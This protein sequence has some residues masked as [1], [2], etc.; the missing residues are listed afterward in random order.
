MSRQV[1]TKLDD[2]MLHLLEYICIK[3]EVHKTKQLCGN[4]LSYDQ[5]ISV[6]SFPIPLRESNSWVILKLSD[7]T[8]E[9]PLKLWGKL[10]LK[11]FN[12]ISVVHWYVG[13][14][15]GE[16]KVGSSS[17]SSGWDPLLLT[18]H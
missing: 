11:G 15:T 18:L 13:S 16:V 5:F 7:S 6:H 2:I 17:G 4:M 10:K 14:A 8:C 1:Y 9:G 12:L 3:K